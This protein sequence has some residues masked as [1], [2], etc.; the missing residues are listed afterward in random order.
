[1]EGVPDRGDY[2]LGG[3]L[4]CRGGDAGYQPFWADNTAGEAAMWSAL[5]ER[6]EAFP[7]APLYHYGSYEKKAFTT[8][9]RRH[10]TGGGLAAR[11]VNVASY[12]HGKVRTDSASF[13]SERQ[14]IVSISAFQADSASP[15]F[16]S[17]QSAS[18]DPPVT[19]PPLHPAS[20]VELLA[21]DA[22]PPVGRRTDSGRCR[23][24]R[25]AASAGGRCD[26]HAQQSD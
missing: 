12:V 18:R 14:R 26:R 10:G 24:D 8:L 9:A 13:L 17:A 1:L 20:G 7:D 22:K 25:V 11:L 16:V 15:R 23:N 3:L 21:G 4:V 5:V 2:Y 6:L 19:L